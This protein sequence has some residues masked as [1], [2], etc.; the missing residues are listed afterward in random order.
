MI[1]LA[2]HATAEGGRTVGYVDN[3]DWISFQPYAVSNATSFTA[4]VSSGGPGGTLEVRAGS[5]T[6]ALMGTATVAPTGSWDTFTNVTANLTNKPTGTTTLFLV[7]KGVTGQ[8]NLFDVDAFTFNTSSSGGS[9]TEGEAFTSQ[10][11]VQVAAHGSASGGATVGFIE[12]GD[13]AGYS[14]VSTAGM[15]GF[16]ARVSSGGSGGTLQIR[17]GSATGTLLGSVAVPVTGGWENFQ[18][19]S[20]TLERGREWSA[21]P[22]LRRRRREPVRRRHL[23]RDS[24]RSWP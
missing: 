13:W 9:T 4:R 6:G 15:H 7:F 23:H 18:T 11:G 2:D 22:V 21:V 3:G 12:N 16:T 19:V 14:G 10:S 17:A 24:L 5:A 8:G 20:T 1:Q